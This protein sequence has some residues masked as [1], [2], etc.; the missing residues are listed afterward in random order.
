MRHY[1]YIGIFRNET[2]HT[3]QLEVWCNGFVQAY[4]LLTADAIRAGK[5]YQLHSI[6]DEKGDEQL[7]KNMDNS[8]IYT[9]IF[10]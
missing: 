6:T 5:H 3:H 9:N 7:V 1:R 4:F 10:K 2:G 8:T